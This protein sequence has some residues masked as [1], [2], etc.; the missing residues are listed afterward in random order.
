M[1]ETTKKYITEEEVEA[2]QLE[3]RQEIYLE[4]PELIPLAS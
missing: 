1:E 2:R 3:I 4:H